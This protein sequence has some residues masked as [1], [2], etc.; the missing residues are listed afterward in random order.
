MLATLFPVPTVNACSRLGIAAALALA[1]AAT[2][3]IRVATWNLTEWGASASATRQA[4]F[5]A[6][7]FQTFSGRSM[8]P[9]VLV[10]QECDSATAATLFLSLLNSAPGSPGDYAQGTF[11]NGPDTDSAVFYRNSRLSLV[12]T[13]TAISGGGTPV[14][15]IMRYR[16]VPFGYTS[17]PRAG[18]YLYSAHLKASNTAADA[19]RRADEA[20]LIRN[21]LNALPAGTS[22]LFAGDFN[23]YT[24]AEVAWTNLTGAGTNSAGRLFDPINSAGSWSN[25]SA[26]RFVHTQCPLLTS[27][28]GQNFGGMDDRFDFILINDDLFDGS[29]LDY[30][31]NPAIPYST[32]TWNDPN[33]SY[34]S[35]G[36]DGSN[37]NGTINVATN[38]MVGPVI[39]QGL[40][41]HANGVNSP[42]HL[43]VFLDLTVP[44]KLGSPTGTIDFGTVAVGSTA[45]VT[46]EITNAADVV[47]F[48][49]SGTGSGIAPL[50]Y[51][52]AA[53]TGFTAPAGNFTRT[54]T[55][56]PAQA[57]SHVIT[58]NTAAP[59]T[60]NGSL[61]ITSDDPDVPTRVIA[62]TG[63]V[64]GSGPGPRPPGNYDVNADGLIDDN[65][66][67]AWF[68]L[69]TD[70]NG[71]GAVDAEDIAF[72]TRG[73]RW[74]ENVDITHLR[75]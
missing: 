16:L 42:P 43:P 36:N 20:T 44:A 66:I 26:W 74:F 37:Y 52:L 15:N 46:I 13:V 5:Q 33:H 72:L 39:A 12:E 55:A 63:V 67:Y 3:Q 29:G 17:A 53:T 35:W 58:L 6:A 1:S 47:R 8:T 40:V 10:I 32:S 54:A 9:D 61:T 48:S 22:F 7:I 31:G 25:S 62:L 27:S 34:R 4:G 28:T 70:V 11:I 69:F 56:A 30:I 65:D 59:G 50:R 18:F 57:N 68:G 60:F 23:L 24:S 45:Q 51:S 41:D 2:A 49:K 38:A 75:R 73:V 19:Q 14:R 71:S 64:G 21:A